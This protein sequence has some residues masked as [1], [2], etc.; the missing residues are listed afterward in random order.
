[1]SKYNTAIM[2]KRF[3]QHK[4]GMVLSLCIGIY[5]LY[6]SY[7]SILRYNTL[8]A[9]YYDL[10]IMNQT[11]YNT[12]VGLKDR[13]LSRVL[14]QTNPEGPNQV[15]RMAIHNDMLLAFLAPFYF[16][17]SGPETLLVIQSIVLGLG[18][19]VIFKIAEFVFSKSE[20]SGF[21]GLMFGIAYL[22]YPA[23]ER[24]NLFDFHAV[25]LATTLLLC[26]FYFWLTGKNRLS[27]LMFLLALLSKEEV[28][29]TT[30]IFG[31]FV[32]YRIWKKKTKTPYV[33]PWL[34]IATSVSWFI[35]SMKLII[36]FYRGG[37]HFALNYYGD[38]GDSP[39]GIILGIFKHPY[40]LAKYIFQPSTFAYVLNLLGPLFLLSLLSP[41]VLFIAVPEFAI[42]LLSNNYNLR[43][44][45]YH[46]TSVIQP[47]VFI[48]AIFGM[49]YL[50]SLQIAR[51]PFGFLS[52]VRVLGITLLCSSLLFAYTVGPLPL[53]KEQ[54]IHP[55]KYPQAAAKEVAIWAKTLYEDNIKISATGQVAPHFSSRRYLYVFDKRYELADYVVIRPT[56]IYN[57][58]EK[59][60]LIPIYKKL[61]KDKNFSLI[62]NSKTLQ[63]FKKNADSANTAGKT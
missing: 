60:T 62:Y 1:M 25:T 36:P 27:F 42:N 29:L 51:R 16:I 10:G 32:I 7:V 39:I 4:Y 34:I 15:K 54:Y 2:R 61:L 58:P 21:L 35:I 22:L 63:V 49:Y 28:A 56:E 11:V 12:Y 52:N 18:A 41:L 55:F 14:E 5:I 9:S 48:S 57:Y 43:T 20:L 37:K 59:N 31:L 23:M 8:Y 30:F 45:I 17:H 26:M 3:W 40:S 33:F 50:Y 46:Y 47:F 44:V 13:D 19:F 6:F 38:F 53:A 24:A